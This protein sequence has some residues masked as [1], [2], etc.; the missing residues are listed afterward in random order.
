MTETEGSKD[1]DS[2][3][4]ADGAHP[5]TEQIATPHDYDHTHRS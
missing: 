4:F 2:G 1:V 5:S 3:D